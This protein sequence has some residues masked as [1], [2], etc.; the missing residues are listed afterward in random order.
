MCAAALTGNNQWQAMRRPRSNARA[1][2]LLQQRVLAA[3]G[4]LRRLDALLLAHL[5]PEL[6]V[7]G[8]AVQRRL[9]R[10]EKLILADRAVRTLLPA[11]KDG[12]V[13]KPSGQSHR[14]VGS[15]RP[16]IRW[17]I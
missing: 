4:R 10:V 13:R 15:K 2:H 17:P 11:H 16:V 12:A 3:L 14:Q 9:D 8:D 7:L 5:V 6:L 1:T